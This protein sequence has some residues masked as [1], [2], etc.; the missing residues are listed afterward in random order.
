MN[1]VRKLIKQLQNEKLSWLKSIFADDEEIIRNWLM[2][3]KTSHYKDKRLGRIWYITINS[4]LAFLVFFFFTHPYYYFFL[5]MNT[6]SKEYFKIGINRLA[7]KIFLVIGAVLAVS[8]QNMLLGIFIA[9][10]A[11]FFI[12]N[13]MVAIVQYLTLRK[14]IMLKKYP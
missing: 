2:S 4:L 14:E 10:S 6:R 9:V 11:F 1:L 8:V 12:Y 13:W 3:A 5:A 7:I